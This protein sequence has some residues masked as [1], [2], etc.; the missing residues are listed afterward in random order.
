M[1]LDLVIDREDHLRQEVVMQIWI[2][3]VVVP[4]FQVMRLLPIVCQVM[5]LLQMVV[6]AVLEQEVQPLIEEALIVVE[7]LMTSYLQ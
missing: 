4:T 5:H 7:V 2:V 1:I 3:E 6:V